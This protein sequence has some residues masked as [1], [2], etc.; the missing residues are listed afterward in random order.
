MSGKMNARLRSRSRGRPDGQESSDQVKPAVAQQPT[1]KKTEEEPAVG[2]PNKEPGQEKEEGVP[3]V[4]GEGQK[5]AQGEA[6]DERDERADGSDSDENPAILV[7]VMIPKASAC[8][9]T[10]GPVSDSAGPRLLPQSRIILA[11]MQI[12]SKS[13]RSAIVLQK[14]LQKIDTEKKGLKERL[15]EL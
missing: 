4:K 9:C 12:E 2:A 15:F 14:S 5:M 6:Q 7:P 3:V 1:D 8:P 13:S 11:E 10:P